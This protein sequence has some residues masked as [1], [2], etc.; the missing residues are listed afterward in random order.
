MQVLQAGTITVVVDID[1]EVFQPL[2]SGLIQRQRPGDPSRAV[3][4][5]IAKGANHGPLAKS[6]TQVFIDQDAGADVGRGVD[7]GLQAL[8]VWNVA[9]EVVIAVEH[10]RARG[11]HP[12][13][14][15]PVGVQG[16][17]QHGDPGTGNGIHLVKQ[18]DIALYACHQFSFTGIGI[19]QL[20]QCAKAVCITI[21]DVEMSHVGSLAKVGLGRCRTGPVQGLSGNS[22][23]TLEAA[24]GAA[25]FDCS[26]R[27]PCF[28]QRWS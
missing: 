27:A 28:F 5:V 2:Q 7:H 19:A 16:H 23:L 3:L 22:S 21:K 20:C 14:A 18:L 11:K 12:L 24:A 6:A 25:A 1:T 4:Q 13:Q 8:I 9:G 26:S 17:V 15:R 10:F